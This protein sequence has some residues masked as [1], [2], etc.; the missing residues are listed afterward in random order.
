MAHGLAPLVSSFP[1][2][3]NVFVVLDDERVVSAV[4]ALIS[5]LCAPYQEGHLRV[6]VYLDL[7]QVARKLMQAP[8]AAPDASYLKMALGVLISAVEQ[9]TAP[10]A[11]LIPIAEL[12]DDTITQDPKLTELLAQVDSLL[13]G[14]GLTGKTVQEDRNSPGF[15]AEGPK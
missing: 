8:N 15:A 13:S 3:A 1:T 5:A 10:P 6:S 9:G 14:H 7:A 12:I 4:H 11:S 2:T